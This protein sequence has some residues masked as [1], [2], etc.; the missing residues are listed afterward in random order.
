MKILHIVYSLEPG[1]MENGILNM[2]ARLPRK[3]VSVK[4]CCLEK[5]GR[6]AE[7]LPKDHQPHVLGK[8][9]GFDRRIPW[10]L[11]GTIREFRP[12]IL[13]THNLGPLIYTA[14]A[15]CMGA[16]GRILH[17]EHASLTETDLGFR[18]R[19]Q[20][21]LLYRFCSGIHTVGYAM[22]GQLEE[23][24]LTSKTI[25]TLQNG[26][27]TEKFS[28]STEKV[29]LRRDLLGLTDN[30][31]LAGVFGRFGTY[32]RHDYLLEAFARVGECLPDLQLLVVGAGGEREESVLAQI[33]QHPFSD[34]IHAVGY[35][36]DPLRHYQCLDLLLIPSVNEGL[37][38]CA[39][40]AMS[41]GVPV[42]SNRNCGAE[43]L[44]A[45][46]ADG[47]VRGMETPPDLVD[48]LFEVVGQG[49]GA[50]A[51]VGTRARQKVQDAF[52][53]SSMADS[54]LRTYQE[55]VGINA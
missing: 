33:G 30:V 2:V 26:V 21:K 36:G 12:D 20:R 16:G 41:C 55:V 22:A 45:D 8:C 3:A 39:L 48:I 9:P 19:L 1:G 47:F 29:R 6:M 42:L 38:N 35:Q 28:P 52:S 46:S 53:M 51:E 25:H 54:Y 31:V 18:K 11:R 50:L 4:I 14:L 10:L 5:A 27:D 40:E 7:R 34:R 24:R 49:S 13:H 32:K 43:E 15:K 44:I 17:G 23:T 37:S